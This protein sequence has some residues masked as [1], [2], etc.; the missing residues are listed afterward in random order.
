MWNVW[1][2]GSDKGMKPK[3]YIMLRV[4]KM[5]MLNLTIITDT[6]HN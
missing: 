3:T 6:K 5:Y 2:L 4:L 1:G